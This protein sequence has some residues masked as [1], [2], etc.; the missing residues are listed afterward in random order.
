MN[1][2][3][4]AIYLLIGGAILSFL[5][6]LIGGLIVIGYAVYSVVE[7]IKHRHLSKEK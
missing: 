6:V 7:L 4:I 5:V 1:I 2:F 3:D